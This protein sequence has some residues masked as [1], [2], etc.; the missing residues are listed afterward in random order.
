MSWPDEMI[1]LGFEICTEVDLT[2][3]AK[4][5]KQNP[6]DAKMVLAREIVKII[7][8]VNKAVRAEKYFINTFQKRLVPDEAIE[9]PAQIGELLSEVLVRAGILSSKGEFKRLVDGG[10][11]S[12]EGGENV[13]DLYQKIIKT[14]V[15][16]IGKKKFVKVLV[17]E[18]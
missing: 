15:F 9:I 7:H 2:E 18:N 1:M 11:V 17:P 8:G 14:T 4:L 13:A 16:K 12:F 6:R 3:M 5:N 10:G